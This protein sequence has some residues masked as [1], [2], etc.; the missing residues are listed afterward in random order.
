MPLEEQLPQ[1]IGMSEQPPPGSEAEGYKHVSMPNLGEDLVFEVLMCVEAW[2][3]TVVTR[4][5]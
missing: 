3:Q 1:N 2:T 5:N 4:V